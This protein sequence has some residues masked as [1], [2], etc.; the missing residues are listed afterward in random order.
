LNLADFFDPDLMQIDLHAETKTEAVEQL[1]E[2]FCKKYPDKNKKAILQAVAEREEL[3]S[4]SF[5]RGFAFPHA[6]TGTVSDLYIA[7][8]IVK[9]GIG[10][11]TPD[12][13][14]INVICLLLT[15]RNISKLYLQVLSGLA[16]FARRPGVLE[17][18]KTILTANDW[19]KVVADSGIEVNT[20]IT[21][22][23]LMTRDI[24]TVSPEEPLKQVANIMFK[25]NFD[26]VPV[27]DSKG[28]LLGD[29]SCQE[30]I[31]WA[32]PDYKKLLTENPGLEPF[33]ELLRRVDFMKV[34][35]VINTSIITISE[36]ATLLE[37]SMLIVT[38]QVDRVMV[39]KDGKLVG[40]ISASDIV[41]KIIR[42]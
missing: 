18:V 3:G 31:K 19:I 21:V 4:T 37:A 41:S 32:L 24:I 36:T 7:L 22:A 28:N 14:P 33:E 42:G 15:P 2:L 40:V 8:G 5:G 11:K 27:V 34:N 1:A 29:V 10:D 30:L 9:K 17:Q 13:V 26:G 25:H 12:N 6:R 16:N 20:G 23:D 39:V 38:K 35:D